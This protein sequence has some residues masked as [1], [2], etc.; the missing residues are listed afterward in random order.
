MKAVED[1]NAWLAHELGGNSTFDVSR[2]MRLVGCINWPNQRK[3]AMG[4]GPAPATLIS[5]NNSLAYDLEVFPVLA[6]WRARAADLDFDIET[7][8]LAALP[9]RLMEII[10]TGRV[11]GEQLDGDNSLSGWAFHLALASIAAGLAGRARGGCVADV[12][13]AGEQGQVGG[14]RA[15]GEADG[16]AGAGSD[17]GVE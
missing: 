14:H 1:R 5:W 2:I 12:G 15:A 17:C 16:G 11:D 6:G 9:P 10:E 4:L 8:D 3:Q 7:P 13:M